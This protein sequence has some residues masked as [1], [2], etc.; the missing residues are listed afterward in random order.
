[1]LIFLLYFWSNT[2]LMN[3]R[4]VFQKHYKSYQPQTFERFS[5]VIVCNEV[6]Y[7]LIDFGAYCNISLNHCLLWCTRLRFTHTHTHTHPRDHFSLLVFLPVVTS[8]WKTLEH[9]RPTPSDRAMKDSEVAVLGVQSLLWNSI[10][11]PPRFTNTAV[12]GQEL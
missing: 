8:F 7:W 2:A 4:D 1:M 3:K 10:H 12:H 9:I 5:W 11:F 6:C